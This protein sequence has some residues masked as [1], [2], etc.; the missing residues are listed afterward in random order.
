MTYL[1]H[2][3]Y[4]EELERSFSSYLDLSFTLQIEGFSKLLPEPVASNEDLKRTQAPLIRCDD[5]FMGAGLSLTC[6]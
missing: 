5:K 4:M 6:Q 1:I 3:P 2:I